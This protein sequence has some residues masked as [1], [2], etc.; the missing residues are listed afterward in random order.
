MIEFVDRQVFLITIL[1]PPLQVNVVE[2]LAL[3]FLLT[4]FWV[5]IQNTPVPRLLPGGTSEEESFLEALC[6][7]DE[8]IEQVIYHSRVGKDCVALLQI[9][10]MYWCIPP[11][12]IVVEVD[13]SLQNRC[14][15]GVTY[16]DRR[17]FPMTNAGPT[18]EVGAEPFPTLR[19]N[20]AN[21]R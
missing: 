18:P 21:E 2:M 20:N 6:N 8:A 16:H 19:E 10:V 12:Q 14:D 9:V 1:C 5:K 13:W 17:S 7:A 4:H 11:S 3:S 15:G